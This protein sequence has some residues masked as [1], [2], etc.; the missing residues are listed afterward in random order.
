MKT[1][2]IKPTFENLLQTYVDNTIGRNDDVFRFT[3]ILNSIDDSCAV[4]LDG[5]WGSGKTFFVK[6]TKMV[7]DAH[8]EHLTGM[9][10]DDRKRILD[11]WNQHYTEAD[12]ELQ[13][14]V[15]VYYDAWE[16]DNDEDPMLSLV[17]EIISGVDT[18][19]SFKKNRN[20]L[21]AAAAVLEFFTGKK[22]NQLIN[23]LKSESP[24][25]GLNSAKELEIKIQEFLDGLLPERGNRLIVMIDELD[26]CKPSYAIKLLE[27]IKHYF[28]NERIT[29]VFSV[30]SCELQKT[31]RS[32]YGDDFDACRYLDRFFSF[33][34]ALPPADMRRYYRIMDFSEGQYWVDQVIGA[35][36]K[37]YSFQ[38]REIS[39]Y[40]P[41]VK[42]AVYDVTHGNRS[43]SFGF[44]KQQGELFGLWYI[45]PIMLGLGMNN[46]EKYNDFISGRDYSP[47]LAVSQYFEDNFFSSLLDVSE[48]F[49]E[50][51]KHKQHV[52][53]EDELK[54]VYDAIFG[55]AFRNGVYTVSVGKLEFEEGVKETILRAAGLLSVYS[56]YTF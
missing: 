25:D 27:R 38:L 51:D 31:I 43:Y 16:N 17:R 53:V 46:G 34:I 14:Q 20:C 40:I 29:F 15:C 5:R 33:R 56:N 4:A 42:S 26:R 48:T 23:A 44:P 37:A 13:P 24:L 45:V 35:V 2:E 22:L 12:M 1:Y 11:V 9:Q 54:Q 55:N 28:S 36:I 30:N 49:D 10:S 47:L 7:L 39:K 18:D 3:E 21:D 6:Q 50:K 8:N 52:T 19:F 41:M 32:F